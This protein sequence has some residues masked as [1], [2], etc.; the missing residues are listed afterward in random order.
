MAET[1]RSRGGEPGG[2]VYAKSAA[3]LREALRRNLIRPLDLV[4]LTRDRIEEVLDDAVERGRMTTDDAQELA[5]GLLERG[6]RQ[7][8]DVLRDLEALLGRS[9]DELGGRAS[10]ARRASGEA[11]RAARSRVEGA[12]RGARERAR[13]AADPALA[14]TDRVRRA[15]GA[16]TGLPIVGYEDLTAQQVQ[17]RLDGLSPAELRRVRDY[18]RRHANR[19]SVLGAVDRKLA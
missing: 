7:T 2:D 15:A 5:V 13:G 16:G 10:G 17:A 3:E 12:A 11:A 4:M 18:E 9:R 14:Q 19:K 1:R 8:N 6:R